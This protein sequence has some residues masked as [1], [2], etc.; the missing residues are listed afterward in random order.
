[1]R[2]NFWYADVALERFNT[3]P[4][5]SSLP[6]STPWAIIKQGKKLCF[7]AIVSCRAMEICQID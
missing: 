1:M 4:T 6:N 5:Y 3:K 7:E 2:G